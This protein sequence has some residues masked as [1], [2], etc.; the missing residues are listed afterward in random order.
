MKITKFGHSCLF[1]EVDGVRILV[2]PGAYSEGYEDLTHLDALLITHNHGDHCNVDSIS[3]LVQSNPAMVIYSNTDVQTTLGE[4]HIMC[5]VPTDSELVT[6]GESEIQVHHTY[7]EEIYETI[8]VP[9]NT[10]FLVAKRLYVTGDNVT[11]IPGE[12]VEILA[13]PVVSP[14]GKTSE[15]LDFARAVKPQ[16][17]I[18]VHDA[19]GQPG[20]FAKHPSNILPEFGIDVVVLE[21]GKE[22]GF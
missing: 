16:V 4:K 12:P 18:P 6:I 2:D 19:I 20:F 15:Y 22:T 17:V 11:S 1:V 3:S 5:V 14:W 21:H 13:L 8:T 10:G 9:Q 7:H